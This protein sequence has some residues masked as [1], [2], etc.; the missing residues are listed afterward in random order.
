MG[1]FGDGL[2][3]RHPAAIF[4]VAISL[5]N[6][7]HICFSHGKLNSRN[8]KEVVRVASSLMFN[9]SARVFCMITHNLFPELWGER[10]KINTEHQC[11]LG[12]YLQ[13]ENSHS[14]FWLLLTLFLPLLPTNHKSSQFCLKICLL[15]PSRLIHWHCQVLFFFFWHCQ[16]LGSSLYHLSLC[17]K[18]LLTGIAHLLKIYSIVIVH[19]LSAQMVDLNSFKIWFLPMLPASS[20]SLPVVLCAPTT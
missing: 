18:S 16:V 12:T 9:C 3:Q 7:L 15:Q 14:R 4:I 17:Y 5:Q 20:V 10:G 2:I 1:W 6:L 19:W 8:L 13:L 11:I